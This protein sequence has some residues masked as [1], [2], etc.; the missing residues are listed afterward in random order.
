MLSSAF[1]RLLAR[2]RGG[3]HGPRL[4]MPEAIEIRLALEGESRGVCGRIRYGEAQFPDC[5][6]RAT[7]D[8]CPACD[9][10]PD[11]TVRPV[12]VVTAVRNV[13]EEPGRCR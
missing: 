2:D 11:G 5:E 4:S 13:L 8:S 1:C 6:G 9:P 3:S 12:E 10:T 7:V